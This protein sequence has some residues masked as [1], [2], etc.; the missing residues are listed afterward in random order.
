VKLKPADPFADP[1]PVFPFDGTEF[2]RQLEAQAK[3][4]LP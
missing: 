1:K 2:Q 3:K 4:M